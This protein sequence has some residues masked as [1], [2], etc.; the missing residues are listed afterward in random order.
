MILHFRLAHHTVTFL[1]AKKLAASE[2]SITRVVKRA[3]LGRGSSRT[4]IRRDSAVSVGQIKLIG[5]DGK[6]RRDPACR[7]RD[8]EIGDGK[9]EGKG[10]EGKGRGEPLFRDKDAKT[11]KR[12]RRG[13]RRSARLPS[14]SREKKKKK[15]REHEISRTRGEE[16]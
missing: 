13:G 15:V 11:Q 10:R 6:S 14:P 4:L 3:R 5:R 16:R 12:A 8:S 9:G 2:R 1:I 7:S